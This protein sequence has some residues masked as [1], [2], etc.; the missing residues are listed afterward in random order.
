MESP[1][2]VHISSYRGN[3]VETAIISDIIKS[4][5]NTGRV[6]RAY[7]WCDKSGYQVDCLIERGDKMI[8]IEIKASMTAA[9]DLFKGV[10]HWKEL[11]QEEG[12]DG[13]VIYAGEETQIRAYG[14]FLSWKEMERLPLFT[15]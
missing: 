3:L 1:E 9:K 14:T 6:P 4:Y 11:A 12:L 10:I 2:A 5:Y 15:P 7:F 13:Y 8:P